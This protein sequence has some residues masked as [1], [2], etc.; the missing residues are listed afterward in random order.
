MIV[1]HVNNCDNK[2]G[3]AKACSRI[4]ESINKSNIPAK[5]LVQN[6]Y[7]DKEYVKSIS[8]NW[9]RKNFTFLRTIFDYS[10]ILFFTTFNIGR[11]SFPFIGKS[12][13]KKQIVKDSDV[14]NLHWINNGFLSL[15]SLKKLSKLNKPIVWTLHDSWAFTGGCHIPFDC[16]KYQTECFD[17]PQ[18]K[19]HGKNDCSKRV[20][21]KKEKLYNKMPNLTI[22]TP[23]KWLAECARSSY[24][25][26]NKEINVIPNTLNT[27]FYRPINK[28][29]IRKKLNL[30]LN[31]RFILFGAANKDVN[32][33]T[34][35]LKEALSKVNS[36]YE[37]I[38]IGRPSEEQNFDSSRKT[39][40]FSQIT[41]DEKMV[42]L[43]NVADVTVVPS[44][45]ENLSNMVMESL[46]CGTPVV[47][48][49]IGG[50]ADMID[51]MHNGYLAKP[52][53]TDELAY[54]IE[55]ILTNYDYYLVSDNSRKK[56]LENFSEESIS[57]KY[58]NLYRTLL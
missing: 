16:K 33:G 19:F 43:Y 15:K 53:D 11:F 42:E 58:I 52:Y 31:K 5:L 22:V 24:L 39:Y 41:D 57:N 18:L 51:H 44:L 55:Y 9:V 25:L 54:G 50:M 8:N 27:D 28:N 6:K 7:S 36:Y 1:L 23:S 40:Y 26:K 14:I 12:I 10:T 38:I 56:V 13:H 30:P 49:N 47:A 29:F 48:F 45:Q 34:T 21:K 17:C 3:A 46:S 4:V 20:F 2:G 37:L 32:K 35:L